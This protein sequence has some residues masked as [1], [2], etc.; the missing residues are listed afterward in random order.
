[1]D[2]ALHGVRFSGVLLDR[3]VGGFLF[4]PGD[5][6]RAFLRRDLRENG[7]PADDL[8]ALA[9]L[10]LRAQVVGD[11]ELGRRTELDEAD[12]LAALQD[13]SPDYLEHLVTYLDD[14]MVL[15]KIPPATK[16]S[17]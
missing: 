1:M 3:L 16:R 14:L 12:A 5:D 13:I 8:L 10:D 15:E 11:I 2:R 17:S 9:D 6:R 7:Q 4:G